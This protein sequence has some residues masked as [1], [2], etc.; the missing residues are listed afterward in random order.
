MKLRMI[1]LNLNNDNLKILYEEYRKPIFLFILSMV[2][3]NTLELNDTVEQFNEK[4]YTFELLNI[5]ILINQYI[6]QKRGYFKL[7]KMYAIHT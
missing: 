3:N 4:K 7:L 2:K 1:L 5:M 6:I